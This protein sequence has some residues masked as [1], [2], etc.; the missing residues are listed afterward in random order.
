MA[1]SFLKV[2]HPLFDPRKKNLLV[3]KVFVYFSLLSLRDDEEEILAKWAI[4]AWS[5]F[6]SRA[7]YVGSVCTGFWVTGALLAASMVSDQ[8]L[9]AE[10]CEGTVISI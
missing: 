3:H 8:M 4:M 10:M 6:F 9:F 2:I 7:I 5:T 1:I